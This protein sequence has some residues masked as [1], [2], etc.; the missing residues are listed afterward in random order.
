MQWTWATPAAIG[1][2]VLGNI[3]QVVAHG[4][5][6]IGQMI[7]SHAAWCDGQKRFHQEAAKSIETI[8][9]GTE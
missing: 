2:I 1:V 7:L 8:V 9:G 5:Q 4:V 6:D 3:F